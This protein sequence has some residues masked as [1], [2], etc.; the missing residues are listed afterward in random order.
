MYVCMYVSPHSP[1]KL[2]TL[3]LVLN[4]W[5]GHKMT[6]RRGPGHITSIECTHPMSLGLSWVYASAYMEPGMFSKVLSLQSM[7]AFSPSVSLNI[8]PAYA[9]ASPASQNILQLILSLNN[10][11]RN[12]SAVEYWNK[13]SSQRQY[14]KL[15]PWG[16]WERWECR[17]C[18]REKQDWRSTNLTLSPMGTT[19]PCAG[20]STLCCHHE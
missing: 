7:W 18:R 6:K 9:V 17:I 20:P 13:I 10:G 12:Y 15:I 4:S 11:S 1:S 14:L 16:G 3:H 19:D 2:P 5:R 8:F